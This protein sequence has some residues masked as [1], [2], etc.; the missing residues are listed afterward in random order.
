MAEN[1]FLGQAQLLQWLNNSLSLKLEKIEEV[2]M[3]YVGVCAQSTTIRLLLVAT[4]ALCI[5]CPWVVH[6]PL[7]YI[8]DI[9]SIKI[10]IVTVINTVLL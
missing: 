7:V 10:A 1:M 6:R 5:A 8:C 2:R 9:D 3:I 4:V